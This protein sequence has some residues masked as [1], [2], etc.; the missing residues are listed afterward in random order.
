MKA[1][2]IIILLFMLVTT[3]IGA[4]SQPGFKSERISKTSTIELNSTIENIFPLFGP[5]KEK[6]WADGWD[7]KIIFS[8]TSLVDE[9]MIFTTKAS[10]LSEEKFTWVV[11][12]FFPEQHLI[13]YAVSTPNRIWFIHVMC[14]ARSEKTLATIQYTF[15]G[16]T[17][18]GNEYN[19]KALE[20]MYAHDLKDWQDAINYH[21][22]TGKK[23]IN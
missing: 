2:K 22:E 3:I 16:L 19:R 21:L 8:T 6:E 5:I 18:E 11:T 13:E 23:L 10:N 4:K 1:L 15:T 9:H 17:S 14:K 7:P 20:K 12:K